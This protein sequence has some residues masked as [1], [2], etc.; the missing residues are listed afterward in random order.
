MFSIRRAGESDAAGILECLRSSFEPYRESYTPGGF[1][2]TV[3][4][5][6]TIGGRLSE[7]SVFVAVSGAGDV[8]GTIGSAIAAEGEGHIRGMAVLPAWQGRGAAAELLRAA[9]LELQARGCSRVSLDTTE[10]LK[11]AARFYEKNGYR[12]SGRVADF[13]GMPLFEYV[14]L[15]P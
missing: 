6:E 9:E 14:K 10:P 11:R 7:M 3:L 1:A 8:I 5:P 15:L 4:S 13:F 12:A 2:D